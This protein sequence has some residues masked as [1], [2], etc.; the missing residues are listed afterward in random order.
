[1]SKKIIKIYKAQS[2]KEPFVDWLYSI[3]DNKIKNIIL[4]RLN[5][6]ETG[7]IGNYKPL[8]D[9]INELKFKVGSGYR[10]YYAE[11]GNTIIILLCG[12][13]KGT[14]SRDISKAKEFYKEYKESKND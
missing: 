7:N 6:I 3:K 5:R 13:D 11:E 12:G 14:Q 1:M 10:I 9:G 4:N 2:G 8:G